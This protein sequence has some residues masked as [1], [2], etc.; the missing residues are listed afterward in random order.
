MNVEAVCHHVLRS[1]RWLEYAFR[2]E[3]KQT[4]KEFIDEIRLKQAKKYLAESTKYKL[5]AVAQMS[6]FN[7]VDQM[8]QLFIKKTGQK[9]SVFRRH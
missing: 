1:R 6:G 8:N 4:P 3:L 7:S 2:R 5:S 9:A